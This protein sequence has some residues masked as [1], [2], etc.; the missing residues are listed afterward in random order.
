V[1]ADLDLRRRHPDQ[2]LE[3]LR[4]AD[5]EGVTVPGPARPPGKKVWAQPIVDG[6]V[7]LLGADTEGAAADQVLKRAQERVAAKEPERA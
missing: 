5:S 7:H 3:P 2:F 6:S 4:S 1:A